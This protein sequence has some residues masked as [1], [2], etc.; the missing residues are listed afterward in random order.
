MTDATLLDLADPSITT[1]GATLRR[2][3]LE[4]LLI[5]QVIT[6]MYVF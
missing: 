5:A 1:G 6:E 2:A 4:G 3:V